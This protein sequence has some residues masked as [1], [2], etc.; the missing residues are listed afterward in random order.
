MARKGGDARGTIDIRPVLLKGM[1][2]VVRRWDMPPIYLTN[3]TVRINNA[4][5]ITLR[6]SFNDN[7][8]GLS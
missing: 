8:L 1:I 7:E 5:E 4:G 2:G 3:G 6:A